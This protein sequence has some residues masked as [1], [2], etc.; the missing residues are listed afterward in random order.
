MLSISILFSITC[1]VGLIL[2]NSVIVSSCFYEK[3]QD[4]MFDSKINRVSVVGISF[5]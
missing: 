2:W 3:C 5:D 4:V 1:F